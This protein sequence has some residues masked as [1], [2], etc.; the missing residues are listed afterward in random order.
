[1]NE[2]TIE[3]VAEVFKILSKYIKEGGGT[4][5]YL[6]YD[7]FGFGPEAYAPLYEAGGMFITN[8]IYDALH[9]EE[10]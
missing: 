5:R 3:Q 6:I 7:K 10:K 9:K 8:F 1:M 4:Y 2:L